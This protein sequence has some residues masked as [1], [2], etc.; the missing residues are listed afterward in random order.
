M[1]LEDYSTIFAITR[2]NDEIQSAWTE[3]RLKRLLK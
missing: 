3:I 1:E 2:L